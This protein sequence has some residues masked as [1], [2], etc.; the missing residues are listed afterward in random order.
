MP[1]T[2]P[3]TVPASTATTPVVVQTTSFVQFATS[4]AFASFIGT[5]SRVQQAQLAVFSARFDL[6]NTQ[7][8]FDAAPQNTTGKK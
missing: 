6:S 8:V 7:V 1:A 5:Y 4:V 3:A 2:V